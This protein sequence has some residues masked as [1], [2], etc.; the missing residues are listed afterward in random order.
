[1]TAIAGWVVGMTL[2]T[3]FVV[4]AAR[5]ADRLLERRVSARARMALYAAVA[6]RLALPVRWDGGVAAAAA[7]HAVTAL[8]ATAVR[9][10]GLPSATVA[11]EAGG[12]VW[13]EWTLA[14][15][16]VAGVVALVALRV[17]SARRA[18][19]GLRPARPSLA[20]LSPAAP[21]FESD[22][23]GPAVVGVT[24]PRIVVPSR[25]ADSADPS[26]LTWIVRHETSHVTSRDPLLLA[27]A[28]FAVAALWPV[29]PLWFAL[30][31]VR[32]LMEV[33]CDERTLAA[34]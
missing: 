32:A 27:A 7:S 24:R 31:R 4:A 9:V 10:A 3:A 5:V 12:S 23:F 15:V 30:A 6:V 17:I 34:S 22:D 28:Q 25:L 11:G 33:A 29:L 16:Y 8:T 2:W 21:V 13:M 26:T 18:T 19:A 1:V 20:A 14:A